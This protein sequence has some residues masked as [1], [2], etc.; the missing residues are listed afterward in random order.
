[1]S[2]IAIITKAQKIYRLAKSFSGRTAKYDF[3]RRYAE[4]FPPNYRPYIRDAYRGAEIAFSGGLIADGLEYF[5]DAIQT[6]PK[7]SS[8]ERQARDYMVK[9]YSGRR[10]GGYNSSYW[11][12]RC[13]CKQKYR[14]RS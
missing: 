14:K 4:H 9:P 3:G 10:H 12:R 1:M 8:K 2:V 7:A 5:S 11:T 6:R 13:K